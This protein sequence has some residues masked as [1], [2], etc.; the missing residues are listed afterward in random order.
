MGDKMDDIIGIGKTIDAKTGSTP[1]GCKM[2]SS[3]GCD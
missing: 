2:Q 1:V 3:N